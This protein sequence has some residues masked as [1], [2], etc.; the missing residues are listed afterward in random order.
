MAA[1]PFPRP[2][3]LHGRARKIDTG[4]LTEQSGEQR[5]KDQT[6]EGDTAA[7]HELLHALAL[8]AGIVRAVALQKVDDT[9]DAKTGTESDNE[10]LK[11]ID[12]TVEEIH[13]RVAGIVLRKEWE[14]FSL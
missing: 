10:S 5:Y 2:P 6:D 8:S 7:S 13:E 3:A 14:L 12:S 4:K 11:N 1:P 9:P